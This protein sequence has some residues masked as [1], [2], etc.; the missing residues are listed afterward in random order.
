MKEKTVTMIR[1]VA[2]MTFLC[3]FLISLLYF[4]I[5]SIFKMMMSATLTQFFRYVFMKLYLCVFPFS[6]CMG[7]LN[8]IPESTKKSRAVLRVIHFLLSFAAYFL[9]MDL[10]FSSIGLGEGESVEGSQVLQMTLPFFVLYP[11]VLWITKLV[12]M[13]VL[14]KEKRPFKSILD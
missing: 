13:I 9:F 6:L 5:F 2:L 4:G 11:V 14:P 3:F 1:K 8:R 7:F 10:L 12:R